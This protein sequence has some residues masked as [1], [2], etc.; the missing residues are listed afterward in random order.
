MKHNQTK[1]GVLLGALAA[2][3]T[4]SPLWAADIE[5]NQVQ[6]KTKGSQLKLELQTDKNQKQEPQVVLIRNGKT[7]FAHLLNTDL[8]L[9]S[10][11]TF[12]RRNPAPGIASV[13]ISKT[14]FS[15]IEVVVTSKTGSPGGKFQVDGSEDIILEVV[16]NQRQLPK[17]K[18]P[19][20]FQWHKQVQPK[21][22]QNT[23]GAIDIPVEAPQPQPIVPPSTPD[24]L[25]PNPEILIDGQEVPATGTLQPVAPAP[26]FLPRAVPPPVGDI[27]V[28]NINT[29]PEILD[30]GTAAV[31]PRLVLREAPVREVLSLLA[32]SANLN[33]VYTG[34]S[35]GDE[36]LAQ[37]ISLDLENESVQD[38]FNTVLQVSGLQ[39]NRRGTTIF[40]GPSL[41]IAARNIVTRSF[42]LNQVETD[43]AAVFLATQGA[44]VQ[45]LEQQEEDIVD[46][47]T[48]RTVRTRLL[49][50]QIRSLTADQPDQDINAPLLLRGLTVTT[51]SRLNTLTMIGEPRLVQIA[52]AMLTQLDA[53]KR[54][55]AV[56]VKIVDVNLAGEERFNTSF[57]FG[58]GDTFFSVDR[59]R[60]N[61]N[62]GDIRPPTSGEV[63]GSQ[64]GRP[65]FPNPLS[66][67]Q[68]F[69]DP[70]TGTQLTRD[71]ST[72]ELVPTESLRPGNLLPNRPDDVR[73]TGITP[74]RQGASAVSQTFF[75]AD[76]NARPL[77]E[78]EGFGGTARPLVNSTTGNLVPAGNAIVPETF[79]DINGD[80]RNLQELQGFG[81]TI[82]P[83]LDPATGGLISAPAD[84]NGAPQFF[85]INGEARLLSELQGFGGTLEPLRDLGTGDLIA[86]SSGAQG[87]PLF[88][89]TDGNSRLLNEL[90]GFGGVFEPLL[91][92]A[93]GNLIQATAA[94]PEIIS[95]AAQFAFSVP[96]FVQYPTEFLGRLQ[97]EVVSG[98]AKILTDPTLVIQEDQEATVK[99]TENAI[100]SIETEVDTESGVRTTT[101]VLEEVGLSLTISV[102]RIDDNGFISLSASPT[103]SSL[104]ESQV[105]DSGAGALNAINLVNR[106]ELSSGL[107]RMRDSQ[108]L[109][110][111]GIIQEADRSVVTKV[112]FLG[113]LPIIGALFRS[114]ERRNERAEVIIL[115]TPQ[116]IDD[117]PES[118][119]G[120]NYTPGAQ[121][122]Q[123]LQER[124]FNVPAPPR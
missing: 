63:E 90:E 60:L 69:L 64:F 115:L 102:E 9:P 107:V 44:S 122:R 4:A 82:Q 45:I 35:S 43:S 73:V 26:A 77:Q 16:P 86:A 112:P 11:K 92:A 85:D 53:R 37:T 23:D 89:D 6:V 48:N 65:V 38:A 117:S 116:V 7:L 101:P 42:R 62:Q 10:G 34:G 79:F 71:P 22:A 12:R 56:N 36:D 105:F 1:V 83:L 91:N 13:E 41:P 67:Q 98:N 120:Y 59:G 30:L 103:V 121:T 31:V 113:D 24:V 39:A 111:S 8:D 123:F 58:L 49:P 15:G 40:V 106:R 100:V 104:G 68:I 51:D 118:A 88:F 32:R 18:L 47:E 95:T 109:I 2:L 81:G 114:T 93:T 99:L 19:N 87:A 21:L 20:I 14:E 46:P 52:T 5:V 17:L 96:N 78:L 108:T 61:V 50:P 27:A 70:N 3:F 57:S 97:A 29:A 76:G 110:L 54:Q 25:I 75:D 124:G 55:V 80:P 28:G 84:A 66:G 33:L 119:F 94:L 72:G 74:G